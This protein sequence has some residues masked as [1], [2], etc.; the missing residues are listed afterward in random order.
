MDRRFITPSEAIALLNDDECIHTFRNPMGMLVGCDHSKESLIKR[1]NNNPDK[2]EIGGS[3][4]RNM[5]H[6]LIINDGDF[7][8]VETN[9]EKL[10]AFDPIKEVSE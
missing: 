4:C 8:F 7:L 5:N 1:I 9:E 10:N 3:A 6:G 2:L